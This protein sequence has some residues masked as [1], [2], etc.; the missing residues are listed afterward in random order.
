MKSLL[1]S[2][3]L[4]VVV[5]AT[6]CAAGPGDRA[7]ADEVFYHFMP[8]AWRDSDND[9]YRFGDFGGMTASL[10]YLEDLGVT[11]VWMNP[12]FPSPAYHGYHHGPADQV[13]SWFGTEADFLAFVAAARA[14]GIKVFLDLVVYGINRDYEWFQD[15]Y[16]NPSSPYDDWLAFT[17]SAN[18]QY[19]GSTYTTWTGGSVRFIHWDLNNPGPVDLV[20]QWSLHWLDPDGDGD[21]SDGIDGY[22][23][24]HVWESYSQGPNGW[25]YN[26]DDFWAPW[27]QALQAVNPAVFTFAEQADWG[28]HGAELLPVFDA[29]MTKPFE[30]AA[31]DALANEQAA[32]LYNQMAATL[33]VLPAEGTFVGIIGDHD[34][35][36]LASVIGDGFAKGKAA[37]AVLLTQPF[38]PIVYYG[39]E[40]GMR[41]TKASYGSDANDIPMREP[42]KWNAVAGAPMSN[43]FVLHSQAYNNRFSQNNDGRSVEEQQGVAGSLLEAYRELI[44][45]RKG[46][47]ALRRGTYHAVTTGSSRLWAFLRHRADE[48]TVL[49]VIN[50]SGNAVA[51]TLDL[52]HASIPG[53][54]SAVQDLLTG[55]VLANLT[56][57]N[58]AAYP[59]SL[60]AYGYH[61]LSVDA[62][63]GEPPPQEID[64]LDIPTD[65]GPGSLRATQ[66]NATGMGDNV[67][68]LN[69][70]F[71]RVQDET[72]RVGITGN[73]DTAGTALM[74]FFDTGPGGQ[75]TLATSSFP[76]PPGNLNA[77]SGLVLDAGFAPDVVIHV[78]AYGGTIYVD[79]Y[80]LATGGG[81]TKRFIGSGTVNSL[82][83]LL[84]GAS[85][86]NGMQVALHNGNTAGVTDTDASGA[87][88]ATSGFEMSLPFADLGIAGAAGTIRVAAML[89]RND[90]V[91]G[92]QFLPGLGGGYGNLGTVPLNLNDVP[93]A[94][95]VSLALQTLPGDWDGD[96][97]VDAADYAAFAAC[98]TGPTGG[99]MGPGCA[100]FDFDGDIDVDLADF[101]VFAAAF[102]GS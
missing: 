6:P 101:S 81:G 8:I 12:I 73:L 37:A 66:D 29:A 89:V 36:R 44:A 31:R 21:P 83:G 27:K 15:A 13:N 61:V 9:A 98:M 38:P 71:V 11:A 75:T 53:G 14:R 16:G 54:S 97:D 70:L 2:F 19:L 24:D 46:N 48:Q 25:G 88:T 32:P 91:I 52:S 63:P 58:Q 39:D 86:P 92:N 64:G 40:I 60:G 100:M 57:S 28:S 72:L 49:V 80:S 59:V 65:L 5:T 69:Q 42:F 47:I 50:V 18:T 76:T 3:V 99:A 84:A 85:N 30:F 43:Y 94:Q 102:T 45:A 62:V 93:G 10:D 51:T 74:L 34:V 17:N 68:E 90:G 23:L 26:L 67:N 56:T 78:N 87:G 41:G 7:G 95:Y 79:H 22:R 96:G 55:Q 77:I 82:S 4:A 33:A 20:T 1:G 35:D